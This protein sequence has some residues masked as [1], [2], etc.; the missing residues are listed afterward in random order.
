MTRQSA[1]S[2]NYRNG[3]GPKRKISSS[4]S[5][6]LAINKFWVSHLHIRSLKT[7]KS[8]LMAVRR[9]NEKFDKDEVQN[10]FFHNCCNQCSEI[11]SVL[12]WRVWKFAR[13]IIAFKDNQSKLQKHL[14]DL[15]SFKKNLQKNEASRIKLYMSKFV[16][17][18]L[19]LN[20]DKKS[21]AVFYYKLSRLADLASLFT[22][23]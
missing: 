13:Y 9:M 23:V 8:Y 1:V 7:N 14:L 15:S 3:A 4:C 2:P 16:T 10:I 12:I 19:P 22:P 17:V 5:S 21:S 6:I 11:V 20:Y 18:I